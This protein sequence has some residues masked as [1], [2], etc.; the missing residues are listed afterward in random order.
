LVEEEGFE[1][2]F[3]VK[4]FRY[5]LK[6]AAAP[7]AVS[8]HVVEVAVEEDL[9]GWSLDCELG[10]ADWKTATQNVTAVALARFVDRLALAL[11]AKGKKLSMYA[12]FRSNFADLPP[13]LGR[14]FA[15]I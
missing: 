5:F 12:N 13:S 9:D 14:G 10:P 7:T 1:G 4:L 15:A 11:H 6:M 3:G 2:L 8:E